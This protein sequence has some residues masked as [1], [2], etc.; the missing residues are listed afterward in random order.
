M[1][2]RR[3][4]PDSLAGCA[5]PYSHGKPC[6]SE[7]EGNFAFGEHTLALRLVSKLPDL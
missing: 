6:V 1:L 2:K 3:G 4:V 5:N 7:N